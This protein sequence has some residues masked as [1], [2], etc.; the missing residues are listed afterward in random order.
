M[1]VSI[2]QMLKVLI[3]DGFGSARLSGRLFGFVLFWFNLES[4]Q[5]E[6]IRNI[7]LD[8]CP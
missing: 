3:W 1:V 6:E 4:G 2:D 5:N 8:V 7:D